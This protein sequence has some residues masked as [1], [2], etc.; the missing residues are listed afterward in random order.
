MP[1]NNNQYRYTPPYYDRGSVAGREP[2]PTL[3][4]S[5]AVPQFYQAPIEDMKDY[6][7]TNSDR[8]FA[9]KS[10]MD[11]VQILAAQDNV[12]D[13]DDAIKRA[14][15]D[16]ITSVIDDYN[17]SGD[18]A[19]ARP[20]TMKAGKDY[21]S[22]EELLKAK[23][24]Y[25]TRADWR[26]VVRANK[27]LTETDRDALYNYYD[28][29]YAGVQKDDSTGRAYGEYETG[30]L[31]KLPNPTEFIHKY[32]QDIKFDSNGRT[33]MDTPTTP[34]QAALQTVIT[35]K[36]G[37]SAHINKPKILQAIKELWLNDKD[38][39]QAYLDRDA[40][41]M[42][43]F[44][45]DDLIAKAE[46]VGEIAAD[47]GYY[48][49]TESGKTSTLNNYA[50]DEL[51]ARQ[52]A[53]AAAKVRVSTGTDGGVV[54][55]NNNHGNTVNDI[56][57]KT[58]EYNDTF[59]NTKT[60]IN[61]VLG[62]G[63]DTNTATLINKLNSTLK[64]S[65]ANT[66]T[67]KD[68]TYSRGQLQSMIDLYRNAEL[69]YKVT[70]DFTK[71]L[72][73]VAKKKAF[74]SADELT[75]KTKT[76]KDNKFKEAVADFKDATTPDY[77]P[78]QYYDL[79]TRNA[80]NGTLST[81]WFGRLADKYNTISTVMT[82]LGVIFPIDAADKFLENKANKGVINLAVQKLQNDGH[83]EEANALYQTV[84]ANE[85]VAQN[86]DNPYVKGLLQYT[87]DANAAVAQSNAYDINYTNSTNELTGISD[88]FVISAIQDKTIEEHEKA[89][90]T[91]LEGYTGLAQVEKD[92][93]DKFGNAID[94]T[95][96]LLDINKYLLDNPNA[97]VVVEDDIQATKEPNY[98]G[99]TSL[100]VKIDRDSTDD[101]EDDI[102]AYVSADEIESPLL[103]VYS[104]KFRHTQYENNAKH[105]TGQNKTLLPALE[106]S[107]H[108][109][110]I[111]DNKYY[112][113][114]KD[115]GKT[116]PISEEEAYSNF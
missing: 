58:V 83:I 32:L 52:K 95:T 70:K 99:E 116:H 79:I 29:Q 92:D 56:V 60:T 10:N 7:K 42:E 115:T 81:G 110:Y 8:Y 76:V 96:G 93:K 101:D 72:V 65:T 30:T 37:K 26:D 36:W 108:E 64:T 103:S 80:N 22:N 19:K 1:Y 44:T 35:K 107:T 113:K 78:E 87:D 14:A 91:T 40:I 71:N 47:V 4:Y 85:F 20:T 100:V 88:V 27:D 74:G 90:K 12:I 69:E 17:I 13:K 112:A 21:A 11:A 73:D 102:V 82:D 15:L 39:Q 86:K 77:T 16:N 41:G 55:V 38:V 98:K 46:K 28:T 24:N 84:L 57:N 89:L 5:Q 49:R 62:F 97:R 51:K 2:S 3:S 61:N 59:D 109:V 23:S 67:I 106:T 114:N 105:I 111:L 68:K 94:E 31:N 45:Q 25:K 50:L 53:A 66:F 54:R 34:E 6:L 48:N 9:N 104:D 63:E 43:G 33:S 18:W 75:I